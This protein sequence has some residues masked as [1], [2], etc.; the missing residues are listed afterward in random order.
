MADG[1]CG[2]RRRRSSS[3]QKK[4]FRRNYTITI[5]IIL[6]LLPFTCY[7]MCECVLVGVCLEVSANVGRLLCGNDK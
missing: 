5:I 4:T 7:Q 6:I 2:R 1:N 3:V